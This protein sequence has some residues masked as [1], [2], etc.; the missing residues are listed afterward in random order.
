MNNCNFANYLAITVR[1]LEADCS[2]NNNNNSGGG[3]GGSGG[4]RSNSKAV[5]VAFPIPKQQLWPKSKHSS[6]VKRIGIGTSSLVVIAGS[7]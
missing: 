3:G 5:A 2:N 1:A 6:S 4:S 7:S